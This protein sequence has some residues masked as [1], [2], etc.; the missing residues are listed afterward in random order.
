MG[1]SLTKMQPYFK[2]S[3]RLYLPQTTSRLF[4]ESPIF[5]LT[6]IPDLHRGSISVAPRWCCVLGNEDVGISDAVRGL[7]DLVRLRVDM[8][9]G[10]DSLSINNATAVLLNGLREREVDSEW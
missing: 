7:P 10:V 1:Q 8:V 5:L 9:P 3:I 2:A 4:P 6:L